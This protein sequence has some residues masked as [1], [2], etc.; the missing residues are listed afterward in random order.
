MVETSE[1]L[2]NEAAQA[3]QLRPYATGGLILLG[4][5]LLAVTL[6]RDTSF[7]AQAVV[8][9]RLG[10]DVLPLIETHV[11]DRDSLTATAARHDITGDDAVVA[12]HRAVALNALTSPAGATLGLA[13]QISGIVISVRLP[14]K[15]Q[16]MQ[17]ANDLALQVLDLGQKGD[18]DADHD[19]LEFY[20]GEEDRLWQE[21]SAL[22]AEVSASSRAN[23]GSVSESARKLGLLQ[24]Q[25]AVVRNDL[26]EKEV[27]ARWDARQRSTQFALLQRAT[28]GRPVQPGQMRL[29]ASLVSAAL[30]ALILAFAVE[31]QPWAGKPVRRIK[32]F[33]AYRLLDDPNRPIFGLPRFAVLSGGVVLVLIILSLLVR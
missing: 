16:A 5:C 25:Y 1:Q 30:L 28:S 22:R 18:L 27:A 31:R 33:C 10:A 20:R 11:M 8:Q 23:S 29:L 13:P 12:L 3:R 6:L 21:V 24:D 26:A 4:A 17:V 32:A 7:E 15:D 14:Q 19:L 9:V 2:G